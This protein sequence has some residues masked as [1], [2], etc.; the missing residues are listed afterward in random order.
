MRIAVRIAGFSMAKAD[1]LRKAMGKKKQEIIDREADSFIAGGV[2]KGFPRDKVRNLWEQIVPFA[3]YGFNKS[4][5]VA[6]AH[7]AY[8]TAYL[9]VH[10]PA[11]FMAAMLTSEVA[12]TDKLAQYLGRCRQMGL[13]ILAPDINA[14]GSTFS[15]ENDCIRFGLTA[16]KGVGAAAVE[17]ILEARRRLGE[18][19]SVAHC[20]RSLPARAVNHKVMECLAKAG[21]F[22]VLGVP[23]KGLLERLEELLDLTGR[24]RDQRALGQGFLFDA[25]PSEDLE[26]ELAH[27]QEADEVDR[28]AW[29]REVLG[30]YFSGHPL[31][32]YQEQLERWSDCGLAELPERLAEGAER[33]TVG[34]LVTAARAIAIK[35][36]GRNQGRR[37]AV[38]ELEDATASVRTVVFPD[39]FER[40]ERQLLDDT[41]VLVMAT[42][43]GEGE[44]VELV[45]DEIT[46]LEGIDSVKAS[47]LR[48]VLDLEH[49]SEEEML[50][51][52][53]YLLDHP[54]ELPVRF[55]LLRRGRFR[56]RLLPPPVVAIDPGS[57]TRAGLKRFLANGWTEYE[58][59]ANPDNGDGSQEQ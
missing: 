2:A 1:S 56:A 20:L 57:E 48:V 40:Y 46:P 7:V 14:S 52:R 58:F 59:A 34:G 31:S 22:D 30:F 35:R 25:M 37:M 29:E 38:F 23:R 44:H 45:A 27:A 8:L 51:L 3:K 41:P 26:A 15:V 24:E 4:H 21:C 43:K 19:T 5:S 42:L 16:I 53:E 6:Y 12:A 28:L 54:G 17:P 33:V 47:A 13:T 39:T 10:F 36:D 32:R 49:V 11:H 9:K 55:E 18:F 50:E